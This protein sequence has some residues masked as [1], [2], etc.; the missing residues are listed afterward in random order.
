M[1]A[2]RK[3]PIRTSS[4]DHLHPQEP[5]RKRRHRLLQVGAAQN[6]HDG[7]KRQRSR[8]GNRDDHAMWST[9]HQRVQREEESGLRLWIPSGQP[10]RD[11]ADCGTGARVRGPGGHLFRQAAVVPDERQDRQG[12]NRWNDEPRPTR[13]RC[14]I[15]TQRPVGGAMLVVLPAQP[16]RQRESAWH[17]GWRI[18][19]HVASHGFVDA[20]VPQDG[21]G[22]VRG[23]TPLPATHSVTVFPRMV[24]VSMRPVTAATTRML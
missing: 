17:H 2:Y 13:E 8:H 21:Q 18:D 22:E 24:G 9:S 20:E 10:Q 5:K 7:R 3:P 15:R 14:E 12:D 1:T 11:G 16:G 23:G 19:D 4:T 6:E